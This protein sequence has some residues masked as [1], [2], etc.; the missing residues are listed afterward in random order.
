M[1]LDRADLK[2]QDNNCS[3]ELRT[4]FVQQQNQIENEPEK[5]E[6]LKSDSGTGPKNMESENQINTCSTS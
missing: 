1:V 4:N 2:N 6:R 3:K 5:L